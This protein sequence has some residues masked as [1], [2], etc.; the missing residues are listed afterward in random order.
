MSQPL[1][2]FTWSLN[3]YGRHLLPLLSLPCFAAGGRV[4][5]R[6]WSHQITTATHF[7]FFLKNLTIIPFTLIWVCYGLVRFLG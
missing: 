2:V 5:Q 6:G 3:F 7:I 1:A 4:I